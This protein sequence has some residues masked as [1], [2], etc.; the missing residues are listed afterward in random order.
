MNRQ[1]RR[2]FERAVN[3][4]VDEMMSDGQLRRADYT[5][6]EWRDLRRMLIETVRQKASETVQ[7]RMPMED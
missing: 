6:A 7:A 5:D 1:Q 3:E 4:T 2:A